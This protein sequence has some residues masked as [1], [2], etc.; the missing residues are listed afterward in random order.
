LKK[1]KNDDAKK[2]ELIENITGTNLVPDITNSANVNS[3]D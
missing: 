3:G 2:K 1:F